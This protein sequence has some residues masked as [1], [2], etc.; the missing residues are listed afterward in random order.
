MANVQ[1]FSASASG[2][3]SAHFERREIERT[4]I[5]ES[6][7]TETIREYVKFGNQDIDLSRTHLNYN[8]GPERDISQVDFIRQRTSE[9]RTMKRADVKV[10]CSWVVTLPEF[11]SRI[12][13]L[14]ITPDREKVEKLFFERSYA[15]LEAR[16]GRENVISAYVHKDENKPHMHFAFIP[17]TAD[18]K[19]GDL[20]VSAKEVLTRAELQSFHAEL[21]HF[22]DSFGD[23]KFEI[24]NEATKEGNK[25]IVELKRETAVEKVKEAEAKAEREISQ[26]RAEVKKEQRQADYTKGE[27]K[28]DIKALERRKE[29]LL[30]SLEVEQI[31]GEKTLFGGLKGVSYEEYEALKKTAAEVDSMKHKVNVMQKKVHDVDKDVQRAYDDANG[32]LKKLREKDKQ[33]LAKQKQNL[34]DEFQFSNTRMKHL[35]Q[36]LQR[37]NTRLNK[38]VSRL[39]EA[40]DFMKSVVEGR[41][42]GLK[43]AVEQRLDK[44]MGKKKDRE[45]ER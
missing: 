1:K 44:I 42:P 30:T 31:K 24:L 12:P 45:M 8:L 32:Q 35:I 36:D 9:V 25:A 27:L 37:E 14:H 4:I 6:G 11:S 21:E 33:E 13:N 2:H 23:W 15:F 26:I 43:D 40:V 19:R 22:L 18:K 20:K 29:G 3:M 38:K 34:A 39:E 5:N 7:Q 17:V 16:Y 28:E 41:L 10:M